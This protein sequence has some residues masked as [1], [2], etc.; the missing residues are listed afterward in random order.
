MNGETPR[1]IQNLCEPI[2]WQRSNDSFMLINVTLL[3]T[4]VKPTSWLGYQLRS[5][6]FTFVQRYGIFPLLFTLHWKWL[7]AHR[8]HANL[9]HRFK[10]FCSPKIPP[11]NF[12]WKI[13]LAPFRNRV[14]ERR[15]VKPRGWFLVSTPLRFIVG[16]GITNTCWW[17]KQLAG[18]ADDGIPVSWKKRGWVK[19]Q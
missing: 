5:A 7:P 4:F 15:T 12:T 8:L 18:G 11:C 16:E 6:E 10:R 19:G 14:K 17:E 1:I 2:H 3:P 13:T 9:T